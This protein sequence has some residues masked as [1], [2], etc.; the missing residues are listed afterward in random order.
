VWALTSIGVAFV[1]SY[2]G[3]YM[4]KKGQDR[5]IKEGSRTLKKRSPAD[6]YQFGDSEHQNAATEGGTVTKCGNTLQCCKT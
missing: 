4:K 1:G 5:A 3:A 6:A 2:L